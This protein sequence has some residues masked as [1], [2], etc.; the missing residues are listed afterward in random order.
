MLFQLQCEHSRSIKHDGIFYWIANKFVS[1]VLPIY[2]KRPSSFQ[3][4]ETLSNLARL[5][6]NLKEKK[7]RLSL[8][9]HVLHSTRWKKTLDYENQV[10]KCKEMTQFRYFLFN[11]SLSGTNFMK[12]KGSIENPHPVILSKCMEGPSRKLGF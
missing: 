10:S 7:K 8:P 11:K 5:L 1:C 9:P 3:G 4:Q 12:D 2:R 6:F